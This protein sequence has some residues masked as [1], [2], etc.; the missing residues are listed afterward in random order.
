MANHDPMTGYNK[1]CESAKVHAIFHVSI[2]IY[3]L[4][5]RHQDSGLVKVSL[6][7][8]D[9]TIPFWSNHE[10]PLVS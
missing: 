5:R 3:Q 8:P 4:G 10:F 2:L 1:T 7:Y 9:A 6:A